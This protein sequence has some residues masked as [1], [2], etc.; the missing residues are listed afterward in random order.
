[1]AN[2]CQNA[3]QDGQW[4]QDG[5]QDNH[6]V[7]GWPP[8]A[9]MATRMATGYQKD[10]QDGQW[11]Q[12]GHQDNHQVPGWPP[13]AKMATRM[14]TGYQKDHQDG[15]WV[16]DGHQDNHQVP[17]WPPGAKMATRM[18]TGYQK[19]HQDGQWVQDGHQVPGWPP[20]ARMTTRMAHK[21]QDGHWVQSSHQVT[22]R[23]LWKNVY[24]ELGGSPGSTS[25]ATCTRRHYERM[26]DVGDPS[27]KMW[28]TPALG[29]RGHISAEDLGDP[30]IHTPTPLCSQVPP[31]KAKPEAA[32]STEDTRDTPERG[33]GAEGCPSP[34]APTPSPARECPSP[35]RT[36]SETYKR[37]FSNFY[38]KGNHP[39]MSPLAKKKLLAQVSKA[40]ALHCHKRHCPQGQPSTSDAGPRSSPEPPRLAT[41]PHLDEE[42]S[43]EPPGAR[44]SAPSVGSEVGPT[45]MGRDSPRA[46]EGGPGATVFTGC[47]H[48]YHHEV[49]KPVGCHPL[50]GYFSSLKDFLEPPATF[51]GRPE[52]PEQPQ[53]LRSKGGQ[54]WS[55]ER[56][57]G[58]ACATVKA[59]WVAPGATFSPAVARGKRGREEE[60]G[61]FGPGAKLRA[62]SP[63]D[64]R[65]PGASSPRGQ[66]GLAKPKAVVASPGY[67]VSLPQAPDVYK[68]AMLHFPA[69]F[70]NPLEHLKTQGVP[71]APSLTTNPFIIP[72]FPSPLVAT[73][74][75]PS[76]L[77]RPLATGPG[78]YPASYESSLRHRLYPGGTWHPQ[79]PYGTPHVPT[80]HRHAKL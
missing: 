34:T 29:D 28:G 10:H 42:R 52:E 20:G 62:I 25:A 37:L 14:A 53:D 73:S 61:A 78:H 40:E 59:C 41:G 69:S 19:D 65:D 11:V 54:S 77:C 27:T 49:L 18:A 26:E 16:Q 3:H 55:G 71:V 13:G 1:M 57:R 64:G 24:D 80:F 39:I 50:W 15:Q 30:S 36:H 70:G 5:H 32:P 51:P 4:V 56:R 38:S 48:A 17:G 60:E 46:E 44:D 12:D 45:A 58:D 75:Q 76:D 79:N 63:F 6:Q 47:F 74:T 72:A 7:P 33:R 35:C 23:R 9:K 68:G 66:Q 21:C 67:A 22:G 43:P 31:E 2:G 8:G